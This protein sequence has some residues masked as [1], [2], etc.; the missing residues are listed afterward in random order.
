MIF[1]TYLTATTCGLIILAKLTF[2][3]EVSD[4]GVEDTNTALVQ[5]AFDD[6]KYGRGSVFDLLAEDVEW[7]VAGVS[8]VSATYYS[9]QSLIEQAV[10]P[11]H[12]KLSTPITPEVKMII[13][14]GNHLVVFWRGK[15]K[16]NDGLL[17]KNDYAWHLVLENEK[18]I[19][20]TA[21]LDT[22]ALSELM[23]DRD[24]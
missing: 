8:P 17:Y 19:Q 13:A 3:A 4:S 7:T 16:T 1:K 9:K 24:S 6:W 12:Q 5:K 23:V 10:E 21:F 11:I 14:Q 20:V 22:W 15:A 18:I 2:A